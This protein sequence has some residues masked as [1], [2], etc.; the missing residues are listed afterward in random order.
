MRSLN[1]RSTVDIGSS[2]SSRRSGRRG[3]ISVEFLLISPLLVGLLL[4]VVQLSLLLSSQQ[5]LSAASREGARVA[6]VGGT[7]EEVKHA[8]LRFL[9]KGKLSQTKIE[10]TLTDASGQP[11]PSGEAVSVTLH[12]PAHQAAPNFLG[13]IGFSFKEPL[14][15]RTVMRKE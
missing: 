10:T 11:I 8:V 7:E 4:A 12:L 14:V 13:I 15:A 5:M 1:A 3:M 2:V 9:G 6:A